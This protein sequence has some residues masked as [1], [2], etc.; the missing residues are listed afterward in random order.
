MVCQG[1]VNCPPLLHSNLFFYEK[2][3]F[4]HNIMK[5]MQK[6]QIYGSQTLFLCMILQAVAEWQESS[7]AMPRIYG[8]IIRT[9]TAD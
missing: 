4:L 3:H 2:D 1:K 8:A 6:I 5:L 7:M 9:L